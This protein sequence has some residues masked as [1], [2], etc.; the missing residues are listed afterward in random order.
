MIEP[1]RVQ[2]FTDFRYAERAGAIRGVEAV[3]TRR[4]LYAD[5][6]ERLSGRLGFETEWLTH[7]Q[8]ETLAASG[9][10]LVP[11][12]GLVERLR[13]VKDGAELAAV[14]RSAA[15][16][17]D[18][19][20]R[21]AE[22]PFVGRSERDIVWRMAELIHEGGADDAAFSTAVGRRAHG[23]LCR[24]RCRATAASRCRSGTWSMPAAASTATARTARARL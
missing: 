7:V 19:F 24:T 17:N 20:A 11:R 1:D 22:R 10:E 21:L 4:N 16:L 15:I 13:Q 6:A 2:L 3:Q 18:A 5:L 9:L 12:R 14:R 23:R 8:F